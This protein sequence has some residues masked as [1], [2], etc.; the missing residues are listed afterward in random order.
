M[1]EEVGEKATT[2]GRVVYGE[3]KYSTKSDKLFITEQRGCLL[4]GLGFALQKYVN[5]TKGIPFVLQHSLSSA[6]LKE[7]YV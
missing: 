6:K 7:I 1:R 3:Q 5:N 2:R 4:S